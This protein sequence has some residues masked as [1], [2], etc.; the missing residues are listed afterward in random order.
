MSRSLWQQFPD[1]YDMCNNCSGLGTVQCFVCLGAGGQYKTVNRFN[2]DGRLTNDQDY[3]SCST[4]AGT[5][6]RSCTEC[7]GNGSV[8]KTRV[9]GQR[10]TPNIHPTINEEA[11]LESGYL[12]E[13]SSLRGK[14]LTLLQNMNLI[15]NA[16]RQEWCVSLSVSTTTKEIEQLKVQWV[17]MLSHLEKNIQAVV[18]AIDTL[19][20]STINRLT[21]SNSNNS[22]PSLSLTPQ[23][24]SP[25]DIFSL[26]NTNNPNPLNSIKQQI[27]SCTLLNPAV[28]QAWIG[29]IENFTA[30]T[31][32]LEQLHAIRSQ[33]T[34]EIDNLSSTRLMLT[35]HCTVL[36]FKIRA[37]K[38]DSR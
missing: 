8:R 31:P 30:P 2:R 24:Q 22:I 25:S 19:F 9:F 10:L 33:M 37:S 3:V 20:P 17:T 14:I 6:Y 5:G 35:S 23:R 4:C 15:S 38:F 18:Q 29:Q 21:Q 36:I 12:N 11:P 28:R 16:I 32:S 1:T 26:Y 7:G 27:T 13:I 34:Q